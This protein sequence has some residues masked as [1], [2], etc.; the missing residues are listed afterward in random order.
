[1]LAL[2]TGIKI[3]VLSMWQS[4]ISDFE[5]IFAQI[6][7]PLNSVKL[8]NYYSKQACYFSSYVFVVYFKEFVYVEHLT[9]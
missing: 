4:L 8:L 1:M 6:S 2:C 9:A 7:D 5:N 3:G